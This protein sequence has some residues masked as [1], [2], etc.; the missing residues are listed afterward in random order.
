M[1]FEVKRRYKLKKIALVMIVMISLSSCSLFQERVKIND[2]I[3]QK[4]VYDVTV[5][6]AKKYILMKNLTKKIV[7]IDVLVKAV[8]PSKNFDYDFSVI[9]DLNT[10]MGLVECVVNSSN[11]N[12]ISKLIKG[13]THISII[14]RFNRFFSL[15]DN[16]YTRVELIEARIDIVEK[17]TDGDLVKQFD[18]KE[19]ADKSQ[20]VN[21]IE[22]KE[23]DGEKK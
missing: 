21:K 9:V 22:K 12:L 3:A 5:N 4:K 8:V 23:I 11:V 2:L 17:N 20:E 14:G 10:D 1:I 7:V 15:L 16:Y 13:K 6:P 19:E 18:K